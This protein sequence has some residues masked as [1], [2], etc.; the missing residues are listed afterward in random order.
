MLSFA[1][2]LVL[3]VQVFLHHGLMNNKYNKIAKIYTVEQFLMLE[4][5]F[6]IRSEKNQGKYFFFKIECPLHYHMDLYF[7][8]ILFF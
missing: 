3:F 4:L 5:N 2:F 8:S 6:I 1:S 7:D